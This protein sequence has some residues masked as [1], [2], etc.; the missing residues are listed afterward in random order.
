MDS[1][2]NQWKSLDFQWILMGTN[3]NPPLFSGSGAHFGGQI[4]RNRV[5]ED[6]KSQAWGFPKGR[7][8]QTLPSD[9]ILVAKISSRRTQGNKNWRANAR[10][11][12]RTA[13]SSEILAQNSG[14]F[15][16]KLCQKWGTVAYRGQTAP[17]ATTPRAGNPHP[18]RRAACA[19]PS[20]QCSATRPPSEFCPP[21][22][23]TSRIRSDVLLLKTARKIRFDQS[24][25]ETLAN[26]A[27]L[28]GNFF[29]W[30]GGADYLCF[31]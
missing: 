22:M 11:R 18:V 28:G 24:D 16:E 25:E 6:Q 30:T 2:G 19:A 13:H 17:A 20:L 3:G 27:I 5:I 10:Q 14:T 21:H 29:L 15:V 23:N 31:P 4:W 26:L 8:S 12:P 7:G 9:Q 1:I